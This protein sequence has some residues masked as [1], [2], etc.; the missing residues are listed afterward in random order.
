VFLAGRF[1]SWTRSPS[2]VG[3]DLVGAAM[4]EATDKLCAA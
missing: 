1:Q 4:A 3:R 2:Y